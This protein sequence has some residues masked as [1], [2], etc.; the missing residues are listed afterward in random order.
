MMDIPENIRKQK[1]INASSFI[2][3]YNHKEIYDYYIKTNSYKETMIKF[4]IPSKNTI[5]W[6]KRKF[7]II[8]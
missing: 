8:S 5:N 3:K 7:E 6:I 1:A 2:K 4:N